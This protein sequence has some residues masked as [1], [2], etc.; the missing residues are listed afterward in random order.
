MKKKKQI[1]LFTKYLKHINKS[2]LSK[3]D[4]KFLSEDPEEYFIAPNFNDAVKAQMWL[5]QNPQENNE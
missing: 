3:E 2:K 1:K 4:I 5:H